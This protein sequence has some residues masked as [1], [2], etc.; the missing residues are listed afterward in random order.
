MNF[1]SKKFLII[2]GNRKKNLKLETIF[3]LKIYCKVDPN[4]NILVHDTIVI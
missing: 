3:S 2:K 1:T 4:L